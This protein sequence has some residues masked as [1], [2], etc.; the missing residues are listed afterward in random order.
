MEFLQYCESDLLDCQL[1]E[2]RHDASLILAQCWEQGGPSVNACLIIF[3]KPEAGFDSY[4]L[5][6]KSN[7]FFSL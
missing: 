5:V 4:Y 3:V 1:L 6:T 2:G 7:L